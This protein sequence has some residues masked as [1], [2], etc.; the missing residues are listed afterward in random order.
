MKAHSKRSTIR[1]S[2]ALPEALASEAMSVAPPG[3]AKSFNRVVLLALSEFV[4]KRKKE[5]FAKAMEQM[6]SD[7]AVAAECAAISRDFSRAETDG[8]SND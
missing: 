6:A 8:L 1:R 3:A 7:P 2:V 4:A 5:A